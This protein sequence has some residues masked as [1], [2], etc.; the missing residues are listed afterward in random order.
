M[1]LKLSLI[2]II[3]VCV[4]LLVKP[5]KQQSTSTIDITI[6]NKTFSLEIAK[7]TIQKSMG[8]S[9]RNSLCPNCGMIF[10]YRIES[11]YPFWM[12]NTLI[13][14]D[15]IWVNKQGVVVDIIQGKPNNLSILTPKSKALYIIELNLDTS[16]NLN[17]NIGDHIQIP[18]NI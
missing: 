10:V 8:L 15:I 13:P 1:F 17:L 2:L 9:N 16:T 3:I 12:K 11:T 18:K 4:V 7:S 14:L 5:T 6:K